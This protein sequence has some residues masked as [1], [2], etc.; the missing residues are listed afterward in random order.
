MESYHV[1]SAPLVALTKSG[2]V[3]PEAARDPDVK[4]AI[5]ELKTA[6][7]ANPVLAY[8]RSDREFVVKSDAATG[9]GIGAVLIQRDDPDEEGQPGQERPVGYYGRKFTSHEQNYSATEAELLGVVEAIKQFRPYLWGRRFRVVTD[10]AA[11]RWLHTMNGTQEGGPQSRLTRWV[12]KLQEYNFYVEH[13]PGK[14]HVD[15]DAISRLVGALTV[16]NARPSSAHSQCTE[17]EAEVLMYPLTSST[18]GDVQTHSEI[19]KSSRGLLDSRA[20]GGDAFG[21]EGSPRAT[22]GDAVEDPS[23]AVARSRAGRGTPVGEA[24]MTTAD[25]TA[26]S[27]SHLGGLQGEATKVGGGVP[28]KLP[29]MQEPD[30]KHVVSMKSAVGIARRDVMAPLLASSEASTRIRKVPARPKVRE[31]SPMTQFFKPLPLEAVSY[32]HLRA[33]ET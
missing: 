30:A 25:N 19:A 18:T 20:A 17:K 15:C 16:V 14:H 33:H 13:K 2:V 6:L 22:S 21:S 4:T 24:E 9:H 32:T 8:P 11:L 7:C 1:K 10:H 31:D 5:E 3:F 23:Y 27:E 26:H 29:L 12:I 28:E